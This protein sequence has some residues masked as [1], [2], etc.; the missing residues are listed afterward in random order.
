MELYDSFDSIL[1]LIIYEKIGK[2]PFR[3]RVRINFT[4]TFKQKCA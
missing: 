4:F 3:N 1:A 2:K